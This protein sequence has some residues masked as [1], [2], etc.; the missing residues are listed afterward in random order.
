MKSIAS[1]L[2]TLSAAAL[3]SHENNY[4]INFKKKNELQTLK[5][6][7]N[8]RTQK[9]KSNYSYSGLCPLEHVPI[10]NLP[11]ISTFK[12]AEL[13]MKKETNMIKNKVK[14]EVESLNCNGMLTLMLI[15][16]NMRP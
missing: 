16:R 10:V 14:L 12:T 6:Y 2:R 9:A 3:M 4:E 7:F 5:E 1:S 11:G 15:K 8:V 13:I